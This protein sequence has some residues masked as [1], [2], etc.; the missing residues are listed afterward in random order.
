MGMFEVCNC[1][2]LCSGFTEQVP[3][4]SSFG[5]C[6]QSASQ[7]GSQSPSPPPALSP[8]RTSPSRQEWGYR[9]R[10]A[11][12]RLTKRHCV[13]WIYSGT[14][15]PV[16]GPQRKLN[17]SQKW[18]R[19]SEAADAWELLLSNRRNRR[20]YRTAVNWYLRKSLGRQMK[21]SLFLKDSQVSF[22]NDVQ[23]ISVGSNWAGHSDQPNSTDYNQREGFSEWSWPLIKKRQKG[24]YKRCL[25][26][27]FSQSSPPDRT[28]WGKRAICENILHRR[29]WMKETPLVCH[30][31]RKKIYCSPPN[32]RMQWVL[33]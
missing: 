22:K 27:P 6:S 23:P 30:N 10:D 28:L 18:D 19:A 16:E 7:E 21:V 3:W 24:M 17:F 9:L 20:L 1:C 4:R 33:R 13:P 11:D 2:P 5:I 14:Q 29:A 15:T 12:C 25:S 26:F 31:R 8:P 32:P